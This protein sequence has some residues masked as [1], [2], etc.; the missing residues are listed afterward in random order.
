MEF[1]VK[2]ASNLC[3]DEKYSFT[4]KQ[5]NLSFNKANNFLVKKD[6]QDFETVSL[7]SR[8]IQSISTGPDDKIENN[9]IKKPFSH[10]SLNIKNKTKFLP[11]DK[12]RKGIE[13]IE[14][15]RIKY[16]TPEKNSIE[17]IIISKKCVKNKNNENKISRNK[18]NNSN[19]KN[20][21]I[22]N[23]NILNPNK[24]GKIY[25]EDNLYKKDVKLLDKSMLK[26]IPPKTTALFCNKYD[27]SR[28]IN[29]GKN[30]SDISKSE[31]PNVFFNHLMIQNSKSRNNKSQYLRLS[32]T[33]R[34]KGKKLTYL[35]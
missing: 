16:S 34:I 20:N 15:R 17:A 6:K 21:N 33:N 8:N 4:L 23:I 29:Y 14:K 22:R 12:G 31:V 1:L 28:N 10:K 11:E 9:K 27:R 3:D 18:N 26:E 25:K 13:L 35:Y 5:G 32:I 19:K 2:L 24:I 7:K 30:K